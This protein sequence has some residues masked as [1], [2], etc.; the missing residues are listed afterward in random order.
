MASSSEPRNPLYLLLLLASLLFVVTALAWAIV[1][2]VEDKAVERGVVPPPS[3]I[4]ATLR[5]EGGRWLLYE[6]AA[7]VVLGVASMV[8]D[9]RRLRRL[10]NQTEA[11]K[12]PAQV[13]DNSPPP[14][15]AHEEPGATDRGT[16]Q[17]D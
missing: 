3:T 16:V 5:K 9:S 13:S 6:L 1:P 8:V 12:M 14:G 2:L 11:G 10:Q 15:A 7:M 17:A 4:R